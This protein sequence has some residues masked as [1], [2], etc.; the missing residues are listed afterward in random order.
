MFSTMIIILRG[1]ST[2]LLRL[3]S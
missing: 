1:V 2:G 3:P